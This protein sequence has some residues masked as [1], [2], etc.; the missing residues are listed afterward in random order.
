MGEHGNEIKILQGEMWAG[1]M[2]RRL[3][4]TPQALSSLPHQTAPGQRFLAASG[5]P[6]YITEVADISV[7]EMTVILPH[8]RLRNRSARSGS[9]HNGK[10]SFC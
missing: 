10:V 2:D 7:N 9:L 6:T 8:G 4:D 5:C 1:P 3:Q